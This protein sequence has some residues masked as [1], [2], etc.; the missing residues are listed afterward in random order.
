MASSAVLYTLWLLLHTRG[1][2]VCGNSST[3]TKKQRV[4]DPQMYDFSTYLYL[5]SCIFSS[6]V[7]VVF[8][9]LKNNNKTSHFLTHFCTFSHLYYK[10]ILGFQGMSTSWWVMVENGQTVLQRHTWIIHPIQRLWA[11]SGV[12]DSNIYKNLFI[13]LGASAQKGKKCS[14]IWLGSCVFERK[15]FIKN[16]ERYMLTPHV[17]SHWRPIWSATV[18]KD[19][20]QPLR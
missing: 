19:P 16:G 9:N 5:L 13:I 2:Q 14:Q 20:S 10:I 8:N 3:R 15:W 17:S 7:S 11:I 18:L 6:F 12:L 4:K 1:D